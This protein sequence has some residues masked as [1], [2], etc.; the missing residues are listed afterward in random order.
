M[1]RNPVITASDQVPPTV[2]GLAIGRPVGDQTVRGTLPV[3][4][5]TLHINRCPLSPSAW[6]ISG[7][8]PSMTV[9]PCSRPQFAA[10]VETDPAPNERCIHT[11]P[12]P[13]SA[14]SS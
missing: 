4:V 11:F 1:T 13:R 12:I 9:I 3:Q 5:R 8:P 14:A 6:N 10:V 2:G 7:Q